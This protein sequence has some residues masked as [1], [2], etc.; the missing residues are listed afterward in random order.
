MKRDASPPT[1]TLEVIS[2]TARRQRLVHVRV[3]VRASGTDDQSGVTCTADV[4][5]TDDT[6]GTVVTGSC[7]NAAGLT[8]AAAP[9]TI[10]IDKSAPTAALGGRRRHCRKQRLVHQ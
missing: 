3:T 9:L 8:T 7:T 2:G 6:T 10:K 5:L 4:N 1:A